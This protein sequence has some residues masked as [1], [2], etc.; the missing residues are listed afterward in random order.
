MISHSTKEIDELIKAEIEK[1]AQ[2]HN[3]IAEGE[4]EED[5]YVSLVNQ[6]KELGYKVT[7]QKEEDISIADGKAT[8]TYK[9][10]FKSL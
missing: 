5:K 9:V 10:K 4:S 6:I 8:I 3:L 7:L 2:K 1:F